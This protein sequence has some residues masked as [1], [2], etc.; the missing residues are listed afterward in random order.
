MAHL[1]Y[2]PTGET[3]VEGSSA[4]LVGE[5][6]RHAAVVSRLG[7]GEDI[8]I[9]DGEGTLARASATTVSPQEI[10]VDVRSTTFHP[11]PTTEIWLVQALAKGDR[12]E[13][14]L[15]TCTELGVDRIIPW[16]AQ[17]SVSQWRGDKVTKGV[18]IE[19]IVGMFSG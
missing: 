7:V 5:E 12:D 3:P 8:L 13:L 4:R 2:L 18:V 19:I 6:A 16:Q 11:R 10:V 1:Y 9:G 17:R 14:A 15:Q